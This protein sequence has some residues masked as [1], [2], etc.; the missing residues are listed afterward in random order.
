MN[1]LRKLEIH[2]R[3]EPFMADVVELLI[4]E[5]TVTDGVTATAI[6]QP[7]VLQAVAEEERAMIPPATL[8]LPPASA[9]QLMDELWRCGLRP[10]EGTGSAGALAATERHLQDLQKLVFSKGRRQ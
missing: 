10:T 7:V 3:R 6:A 5:R 9:Q 8:T 4:V 1:F 2:A